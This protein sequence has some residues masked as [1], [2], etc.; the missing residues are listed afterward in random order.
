M[1]RSQLNFRVSE[2]R[3]ARWEEHVEETILYDKVSELI[4]N[5][6]GNQ[7]ERDTGASISDSGGSGDGSSEAV[8]GVVEDNNSALGDVREEL[9]ALRQEVASSG[10]V[11]D[12]VA[13]DVYTAIPEVMDVGAVNRHSVDGGTPS[14]IAEEAG[15][16]VEEADVALTQLWRDMGS[17]GMLKPADVDEPIYYREA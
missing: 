6:V 13:S 15:V 2:E 17:I 1:A 9:K 3:R 8:L 10:G 5:A 12:S 11:S 7:I 16:S 14:D 4:K